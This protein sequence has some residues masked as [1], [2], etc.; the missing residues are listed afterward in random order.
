MTDER[1]TPDG[2]DQFRWSPEPT[3]A[4]LQEEVAR[5][6]IALNISAPLLALDWP[7][8]YDYRP[9]WGYS[10]EPHPILRR[11]L[12]PEKSS[13]RTAIEQIVSFVGE[14]GKIPIDF[15]AGAYEL[16]GWRNPQMD[17]FDSAALFWAT[18]ALRPRT[19]IEI[20]SGI[21]TLFAHRG[22]VAAGTNTRIISIDPAPRASV[23]SVCDQVFRF[24][25]ESC[26][27]TIFDALETGDVV[28][29]D[30]SHRSFTNSDVTVFLLDVVPRLRAG[31]IIGIHDIHWPFD[32]SPFYLP[33]YWNEQYVLGTA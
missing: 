10:T 20:G 27:L 1:L 15:D 9:R 24:G 25:L 30:G 11:L 33:W 6:R 7:P 16:P 23:D 13:Y 17:M 32:Y 28:F 14:F 5:L 19:F 21:S 2:G 3:M 26:D 31:V 8:S 29:F 22:R 18:A 12:D 4:G